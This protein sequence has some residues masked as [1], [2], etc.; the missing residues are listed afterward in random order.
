MKLR[1]AVRDDAETV[2]EIWNRMIRDTART[3][4]TEAKPVAAMRDAIE[5]RGAGFQVAEIDGQVVGFAT[6]F[7]FRAGPGYV[8]TKEHSI[9]LTEV[10]SG[11]GIG[12]ALMTQLEDAA[13]AE[14]VHSLYA[15][16]SGENPDGVAFHAAI[17]FKEIARLPEVGFKFGRW[18]DLVL[19]QKFL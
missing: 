13:R 6:Y 18:M 10:A 11:R 17:G 8:H 12:R 7:P 15:G 16:I 1:Q 9:V 2:A 4:T 19:M 3:F 14:G 5:T